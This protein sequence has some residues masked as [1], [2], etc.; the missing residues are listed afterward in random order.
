MQQAKSE[1]CSKNTLKKNDINNAC[2]FHFYQILRAKK[3]C[4]LNFFFLLIEPC[5]VDVVE[6]NDFSLKYQS[7]GVICGELRW[8][9]LRSLNFYFEMCKEAKFPCSSSEWTV[10]FSNQNL[11]DIYKGFCLLQHFIC[12]EATIELSFCISFICFTL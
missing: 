1:K 9:L 3:Y 10:L 5:Y 7:T 4:D 2:F 11:P 8:K 6:T 12:W